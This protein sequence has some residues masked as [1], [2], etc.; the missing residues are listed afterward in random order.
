MMAGGEEMGGPW[1]GEQQEGGAEQGANSGGGDGDGDSEDEDEDRGVG[2]EDYSED[3]DGN[4][5]EVG[6]GQRGRKGER[7]DEDSSNEGVILVRGHNN[8]IVRQPAAANAVRFVN[9]RG[10]FFPRALKSYR[11]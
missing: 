9:F 6:R 3:E 2:N 11:S 5:E 1:G 8:F 10:R 7:E 4:S